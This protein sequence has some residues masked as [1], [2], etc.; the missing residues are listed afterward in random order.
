[1]AEVFGRR[2]SLVIGKPAEII[3]LTLPR[4]IINP[5]V[6]EN[7][8]SKPTV[9]GEN[10]TV[11]YRVKPNRFIEI[12]EL[13]MDAEIIYTVNNKSKGGNQNTTIKVYNLSEETKNRITKDSLVLLRAGYRQD[14][15]TNE[16]ISE[17]LP[18][19]FCG[20]IMKVDTRRM[21]GGGFV[22]TLI[23]GDNV[24]PKNNLRISQS[25]PPNTTKYTVLKDM[26]NIVKAN[27]VPIA[28]TFDFGTD[29][30]PLRGTY[31]SGY[32]VEGKLFEEIS[33]VALSLGMLFYT[34]L[35]KVYVQWKDDPK[36]FGIVN[37]T[38]DNLKRPIENSDDSEE[39]VSA[40]N[41]SVKGITLLTFLNG[42]IT[43][44]KLIRVSNENDPS[45]DGDYN[46]T[47]I[48][49]TLNFEGDAWDTEVE[50][51]RV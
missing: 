43:P 18:L 48:K 16:E 30:P 4:T 49:H 51:K 50:C 42:N 13:N 19:V 11:D 24:I 17:D 27:G 14:F 28:K 21:N 34:A 15:T 2:Y 23:C 7:S 46:I 25:W 37:I 40:E 10:V 8:K 6:I 35:G 47:S 22:T 5:T 33:K 41:E 31:L 32:N 12:K 38:T 3:K 26:L 36:V 44:E 1:M 9:S 29:I 39:N 20:T 45:K